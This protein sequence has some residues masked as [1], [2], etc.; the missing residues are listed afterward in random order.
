MWVTIVALFTTS[1][2]Q[3]LL[4]HSLILSSVSPTVNSSPRKRV[5]L[6]AEILLSPQAASAATRN[7]RPIH[8]TALREIM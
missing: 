1:L 8:L 3:S 6:T 2:V 5:S 7:P 4:L